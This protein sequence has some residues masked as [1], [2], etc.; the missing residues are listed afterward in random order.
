MKVIRPTI[1]A[2]VLIV[3]VSAFV[4]GARR[5]SSEVESIPTSQV[6]TTNPPTSLPTT[7]T[8]TT[9]SQ[10]T[11]PGSTV[12]TSAAP[13]STETAMTSAVANNS[14]TSIAVTP[15]S[16]LDALRIEAERANG[17][18]RD[19][20]KHWIDDDRNGCDT[21]REVL[22]AESTTPVVVG[23]GCSITGGTWFSAYDGV[24]T[25][26]ASSFDIDHMVPLKEAWDS[27]AYSW[28]AATR[29]SFANDLSLDVSLIAVS[30]SS[31]RS[32]S[33]RDP[34]DWLPPSA[35]YHCTYVDSWI[36]V[37]RAWNLAVDQSEYDALAAVLAGC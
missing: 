27:G 9:T 34:A 4:I 17:Y 21:R 16:P 22:I 33:D 32:K 12:V 19:L 13:T 37:K 15:P 2:I 8:L 23:A 10:A 31:N 18:D 20:F 14:A 25:T 3:V 11:T 28:D 35:N 29:Q 26:N 36:A 24:T 30:A 5:S 7:T 6:T 1:F